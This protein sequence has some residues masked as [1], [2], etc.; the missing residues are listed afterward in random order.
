MHVLPPAVLHCY[1]LLSPASYS[2][3]TW[4]VHFANTWSNDACLCFAPSPSL[5]DKWLFSLLMWREESCFPPPKI[6]NTTVLEEP[7]CS[8][9]FT[10][11][12]ENCFQGSK[13]LPAALVG[14]WFSFLRLHLCHR[15][16]SVWVFPYQHS[17]PLQT[18]LNW[19]V[20]SSSYPP[21][22]SRLHNVSFRNVLNFVDER[23]CKYS[24]LDYFYLCRVSKLT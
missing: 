18:E 11:K 13:W 1:C 16:A 14:P 7:I 9:I 5:R 4:T 2:K 21:P 23:S 10:C 6:S 22:S 17:T 19:T 8:F 20:S 15:T 3:W 12:I 24:L